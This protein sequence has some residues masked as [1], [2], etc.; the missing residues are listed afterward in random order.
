MEEVITHW[1]ALST[2]HLYTTTICLPPMYTL[3]TSTNTLSI[4]LVYTALHA[5]KNLSVS[6]NYSFTIYC[7]LC[8]PSITASV[9]SPSW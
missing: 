1:G 8:A 9:L 5:H 3:C 6:K 4:A 2:T 7:L